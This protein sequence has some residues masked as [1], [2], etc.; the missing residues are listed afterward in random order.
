VWSLPPANDATLEAL[1][2]RRA[3][4]LLLLDR[5]L[6]EEL[7]RRR[8]LVLVQRQR[9]GRS[10]LFVYLP[11]ERARLLGQGTGGP[12]ELGGVDEDAGGGGDGGR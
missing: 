10:R 2:D 9:A 8:G 12:I 1:L 6:G 5:P 7:V 4:G 11:I 3:V